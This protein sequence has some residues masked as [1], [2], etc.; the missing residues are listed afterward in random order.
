MHIPLSPRHSQVA[1]F[2]ADLGLET[3]II[4]LLVL[5]FGSK[6]V[7]RAILTFIFQAF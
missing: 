2:T 5:F 6:V 7:R 4:M 1:F 3:L